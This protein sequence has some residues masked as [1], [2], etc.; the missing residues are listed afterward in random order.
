MKVAGDWTLGRRVMKQ[1]FEALKSLPEEKKWET[2]RMTSLPTMCQ[3]WAKKAP[4][5]PSRPGE[6]SLFWLKTASLI[7][8]GEGIL[9]KEMLSS[10]ITKGPTTSK[11]TVTEML[12][13]LKEFRSLEK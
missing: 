7:S 6:L 9:D 10:A 2:A 12:G 3:H 1:A 5:N 13:G 4:E 8:E 11:R